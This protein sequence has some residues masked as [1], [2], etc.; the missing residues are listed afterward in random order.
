MSY[1]CKRATCGKDF[2]LAPGA[3]V[4]EYCSRSCASLARYENP[5]Y[6]AAHA[7]AVKASYTQELLAKRRS[8]A[9]RQIEENPEAFRRFHEAARE[10]AIGRQCL[11]SGEHLRKTQERLRIHNKSDATR[12]LN[13][14]R[15]KSLWKKGHFAN[16]KMG[17]GR[18]G[19]HHSQKAGRVLY[20]SSYELKAFTL[21]D[22]DETVLSYE[23][24]PL[25][26]S[27]GQGRWYKPDLLVYY[28]AKTL[29]VEIKAKWA[30]TEP[31]V[32]AKHKAAEDYVSSSAKIDKFVVWT[33]D[34]LW[35]SLSRKEQL[36][37][38]QSQYMT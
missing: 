22:N 3:Y 7:L 36:K 28:E 35:P 15:M 13:S 8:D 19:F 2:E 20:R 34:D 5:E 18:S 25:S 26:I 23:V 37:L 12:E 30:L 29:L 14:A 11:L 38:Q 4:R 6:K 33:E 10:A 9:K 1:T 24:E 21:L 16:A 32:V 17:R 27:Y 31:S